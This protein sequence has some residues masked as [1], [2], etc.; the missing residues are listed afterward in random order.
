VRGVAR[1]A[2]VAHHLVREDVRGRLG[3]VALGA[4]GVARGDQG[5]G[6]GAGGMGFT[7]VGIVAIDAADLADEHGM[8]VRQA[9]FGAGVDVA[10]ETGLRGVARIDDGGAGAGLDMEAGRA[11][12]GFAGNIFRPDLFTEGDDARVR[13]I[14]KAAGDVGVAAGARLGADEFGARNLRRHDD[15]AADD[16]A[17]DDENRPHGKSADQ[18][19]LFGDGKAAEH[20][21]GKGGGAGLLGERADE[22]DY[23]GDFRIAQAIAEGLHF[24]L[25]LGVHPAAL[26]QL[27]NLRRR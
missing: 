7:L 10:L 22:L 19:S 16:R 18:Q 26:H 23:R 17:R 4:G 5:T 11:V 9:E 24:L 14:V 2:A 21:G 27:E 3:R 13:G 1:D 20:I 12:A 15:G 6:A 25:T 8:G